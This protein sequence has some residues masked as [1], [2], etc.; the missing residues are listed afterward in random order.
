MSRY[1]NQTF[2]VAKIVAGGILLVLSLSV[3]GCS[4]A[5]EPT[6]ANSANAAVERTSEPASQPLGSVKTIPEKP[7][8]MVPL[9]DM[10]LG[11]ADA[12]ITLIEYASMT[13]SHCADFH[14][15]SFKRLKENYV[16]TGKVRLV[17]RE[18][19][20][21]Q[22]ALEASVFARCAGED[23]YFDVVDMLFEK[24]LE[25]VTS[26]NISGTLRSYGLAEGLGEDEYKACQENE[27]LLKRLAAR[28]IEGRETYGVSA[29][30]SLVING[31]LYEGS[32]QYALLAAF[33]DNLLAG[34]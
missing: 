27:V 5:N 18:F 31:K 13:C 12:P 1:Q 6:A 21:D 15:F 7:L 10:V 24:Q 29:T 25:W 2:G 34:N 14:K 30:P 3:S 22:Y 32:R 33:L 26:R 11:S 4:D 16:D 20:L 17:F 19:P 23:R 8:R 28:R 9:G